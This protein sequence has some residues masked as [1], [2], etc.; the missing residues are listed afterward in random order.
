M[1]QYIRDFDSEQV[2]TIQVKNLEE[3]KLSLKKEKSKTFRVL[4]TNIRSISKNLDEF[5][6]VLAQI[7]CEMDCIV[8]SETWEIRNIDLYHIAGYKLIYNHS[9]NSQ[10]DGL[11]V[12]I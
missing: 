9:K 10:N 4:H 6:V 2:K 7:D 3:L 12:F 8:F 11:V 5:R 1:D